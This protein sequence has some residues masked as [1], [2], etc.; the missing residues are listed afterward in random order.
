M[1]LCCAKCLKKKSKDIPSTFVWR[2]IH[3]I[4]GVWLIIFLC[5]HFLIN[6]QA[7]L[8]FL[9]DGKGFI[10]L[11]NHIYSIPLLPVVEVLFLGIPFLIHM[12]WGVFYLRSG[13]LNSFP[14]NGSRPALGMLRRNRCY[15]WQRITS[16]I[17]LVGIVAHVVQLRF[18]EYPHKVVQEGVKY[19][20][21]RLHDDPGLR[22]VAE[23]L[24][25]ELK[26]EKDRLY[27]VAPSPGTAF[28]LLVRDMFKNPILVILYSIFVVAAAFHAFNGL[29]TAMITWGVTVSDRSQR[30]M[31]MV[32]RSLMWIVGFLGLAAIWGTYWTTLLQR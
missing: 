18:V 14:T 23:R 29:W 21:V 6:S 17:L 25:I 8:F 32:T 22:R 2:R 12:V 26:V 13:E 28:F 31:G 30:L 7:A 4:I 5:E 24:D 27:A 15:S 19:Y 9:N 11:V 1:A 16:W 10:N 3:S 20:Q